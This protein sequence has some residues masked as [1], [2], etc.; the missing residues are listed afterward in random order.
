MQ[1]PFSKK[2]ILDI[3]FLFVNRFS[4]FLRHILWLKECL[5]NSCMTLIHSVVIREKPPKRPRIQSSKHPCLFHC[6]NI[7]QV[8]RRWFEHAAC[9]LVFKQLPLDPANVNAWKNMGDPYIRKK[10]NLMLA[11]QSTVT[12]LSGTKV[13]GVYVKH[14]PEVNCYQEAVS[15]NLTFDIKRKL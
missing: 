13:K 6:I 2:N 4:K 5:I 12:T 7:C 3:K 14:F 1:N 9:G 8:P 15:I 11:R 10:T